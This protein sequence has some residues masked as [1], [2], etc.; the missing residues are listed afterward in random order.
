MAMRARQ[1]MKTHDGIERLSSFQSVVA[2]SPEPLKINDNASPMG[3]L[4]MIYSN[5]GPQ[6]GI[7]SE[8][9]FCNQT[10]QAETPAPVPAETVIKA[11]Y[12]NRPRSLGF[13]IKANKKII[14][15]VITAILWITQ[16]GHGSRNKKY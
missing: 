3:K 12:V 2:H 9:K 14:P 6:P 7:L 5:P 15:V 4:L 1:Q 10:C 11:A 13:C 8:G 16:S